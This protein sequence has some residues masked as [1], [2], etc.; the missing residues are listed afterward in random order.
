MSPSSDDGAPGSGGVRAP[1]VG[2]QP[3]IDGNGYWETTSTGVNLNFGAANNLGNAT[4]TAT[5]VGISS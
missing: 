1:V 5:V 3:T 2:L 4:P